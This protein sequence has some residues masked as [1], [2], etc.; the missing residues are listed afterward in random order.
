MAG[1]RPRRNQSQHEIDNDNGP[2]AGGDRPYF[3]IDYTTCAGVII[4]WDRSDITRPEQY[5]PMTSQMHYDYD[6][7]NYVDPAPF[8]DTP[9]IGQEWAHYTSDDMAD[10]VSEWNNRNT[11]GAQEPS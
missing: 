8:M 5:K 7:G 1:H 6:S 4:F 3:D 10:K 11:T 9:F 2:L